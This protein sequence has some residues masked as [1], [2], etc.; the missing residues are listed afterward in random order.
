MSHYCLFLKNVLFVIETLFQPWVVNLCHISVVFQVR[1][2]Y[3]SLQLH[4]IQICQIFGTLILHTMLWKLC[5]HVG[6]ADDVACFTVYVF[7]CNTYYI[8]YVL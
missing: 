2:D 7:T 8:L 6:A 4:L 5:R 1:H 3:C